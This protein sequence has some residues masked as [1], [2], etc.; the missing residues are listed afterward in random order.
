MFFNDK[1]QYTGFEVNDHAAF[2]YAGKDI[3]CAGISILVINTINSIES[4]TDDFISYDVDE[5]T[6]YIRFSLDGEGSA[7]SKVLLQAMVLGLSELEKQYK[8]YLKLK[9]EEV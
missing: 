5:K 8:K 7:E 4:F 3:V 9:F 1:Q 6:G 2:S